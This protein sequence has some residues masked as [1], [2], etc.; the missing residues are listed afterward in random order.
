MKSDKQKSAEFWEHPEQVKRFSQRPPDHR[1]AELVNKFPSPRQTRVL[2]LG[3]AGGRNIVFLLEHS[4]D[5][6]AIDNSKAMVRETRRRAKPYL[7]D[8]TTERIRVGR[9]QDLSVF[10]NGF[11]DLIVALGILHLAKNENEFVTVL[12]ELGRILKEQ[13]LLLVSN[14][15]RGHAPQGVT[16]VKVRDSKYV[17]SGFDG[18]N[19][20]LPT[21]K[22]LDKEFC[23]KGFEP[24][25]KTYTIRK[26]S[27]E[28]KR[29]TVNALY[30]K[31]KGQNDEGQNQ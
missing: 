20:C 3:C 4:F 31:V 16:P 19:L 8:K 15:S 10:K 17:Y 29:V 23:K 7:A 30:K 12:A 24:V 28:G 1:L 18:G 11:F 6:W 2:D 21:E 27:E 25:E 13:G 5:V 14:F 22:Q 26:E 9:M